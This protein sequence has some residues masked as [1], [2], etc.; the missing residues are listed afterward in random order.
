MFLLGGSVSAGVPR[1]IKTIRAD[2]IKSLLGWHIVPVG[3]QND[4]GYDDILIWEARAG[5]PSIA[6]YLGGNPP[7]DTAVMRI[8]DINTPV[9]NVG[10]INSDGYD[11]FAMQGRDSFG[12]KHN[13]YYGGPSF[14]TVRDLWFGLDTLRT[15]IYTARGNDINSNGKDDIITG[16]SQQETA[17]L[18]ELGT[19][20]DSIPD[21]VFRP[22]AF[23]YNGTF[24]LSVI[25]G[26]F[27][28]DD[29]TD[30]AISAIPSS[31]FHVSGQV[32]LYFGGVGFDTLPDMGPYASRWQ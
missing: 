11:D 21:L 10:D 30:L 17:L 19:D 3:D 7:A 5:L 26:D 8:H 1:I 28:G 31:V 16:S 27:N 25:S 12:W 24:S 29:T 6:L 13:L 18:F 4:D 14:D 9:S 2:T 15:G 20:S 23:P 22:I 32:H